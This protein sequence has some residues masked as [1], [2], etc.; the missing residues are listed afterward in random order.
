MREATKKIYMTRHL[1]VHTD[2]YREDGLSRLVYGTATGNSDA[3]DDFKQYNCL[4]HSILSGIN[5]VDTGLTFRRYR[6]EHIVGLV[7]RTLIT[8]YGMSRSEINLIS[9]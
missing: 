4:K 3:S 2:N 6:A 9:K 7:L 8:K 5:Q 1:N